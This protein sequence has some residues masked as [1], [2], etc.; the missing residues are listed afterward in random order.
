[1]NNRDSKKSSL[2]NNSYLLIA[3]A[4]AITISFIID[5][6]WSGTSTP[7]I[8]Q[9]TIQKAIRK[10]Q[11]DFESFSRDT[12]LISKLVSNQYNTAALQKLEQKDYFIFIYKTINTVSDSCIFWSTQVVQPDLAIVE[13]F[14]NDY[15]ARLPNG[16]YV[17]NKKNIALHNNRYKIISLIPVKWNYYVVNKYLINSFAAVDKIE[18]DYEITFSPGS[19]VIKSL[20]GTTLFYLHQTGANKIVHNNTIALWLKIIAALLVLIF[21]NIAANL[22]V[23]QYGFWEGL[24]VLSVP[25]I[26]LRILSYFIAIPL[27]FR[28]LELFDPVIY[29]SSMILRSLGD[30]LINSLLF[31]WFILF[32]RYHLKKITLYERPPIGLKKTGIVAVLA[33]LMILVTFLCGRIIKSLVADS[34]ISFDVINFFTINIYSVVGFIVLCCMATGY[35]FLFQILSYIL[36]PL[37]EDRPYLMYFTLAILG[38]LI[39]SVS[40][41]SS[42]VTFNLLLLLWLL[43][44][45]FLMDKNYHRLLAARLISS[46]YVFWI[47]FFSVS[48]S[49]IIIFENSKKEFGLRK[50]FAEN[51][52]NKADTTSEK[53]LNFVVTDF[54]ND[55]LSKI[56]PQFTN[57]AQNRYIKDSLINANFSAY[58]SRYDTRVYTFDSEERPLYNVDSTTFNTLNTITETQGRSTGTA[59]LYYYDVS[60]DVFNYIIKK[61]VIDT[62]GVIKGYVYILSNPKRYKNN[63]ALYPELF[64]KGSVNSIENSSVYAFAI[65]NK[66]RLIISHNDYPFS[67]RIT[68][69]PHLNNE[70]WSYKK[71]GY[72]ELWYKANEDKII[73]ITK[74]N[75][76]FIESIT[77]FAYLFCAFL[78]LS[79]LLLLLNILVQNKFNFSKIKLFSDLS[80]RTQI[81][82]TII[83]IS[84]FSFVIIGI[85]TILFFISRYHSNNREKLSRVIQVM[86]NEVRDSLINFTSI[87]ADKNQLE[88]MIHKVS[89]LYSADVNLYDLGG[90]L[91]VSSLPLPYNTGIVSKK[92]DP[93]AFYHLKNLR[94]VQFFQEQSIGTLSYL[95]NYVPVRNQNGSEIAYLNIPYFESENKL[96]EEISN[97]LVTIINL[98]AFIFLVAGIIALFITNRVTQSFSLISNKMKQVNL[99]KMNEMIVWN[100]KDEIGELVEEYNK[101]VMKLDSS[102]EKLARSER[103]GAWREMARQVAHEIKNPLTPMRLNLQYLQK[104]IESN[105]PNVKDISIYVAKIL[106]E[107]IDHLSQIAGDFAQF[108]NIGQSK[109]Q[110]FNLA[111]SLKQVTS[112]YSSNEKLQITMTPHSDKIMIKADKTQ[113]NRL[114]TNLL[115]NAVESVPEEKNAE[116]NIATK[117]D[118][119][120][121]LVM[122][123]DNGKGIPMDMRGKIFTPNFTTKSSGTGLGLAMCKGIVEKSNGDIW[124]ETID[125]ESTTFFVQLPLVG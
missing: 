40:F 34:Q 113:I 70:F 52:S 16:W 3:A 13:S 31:V 71:N 1:L 46:R 8:V 121:V 24:L 109:N 21:I 120:K 27:N 69:G 15:L 106:V 84:I 19:L 29:G 85:T 100:K 94:D 28:Q 76:F 43:L 104:A 93:T 39:L 78:A 88:R 115:Q 62:S 83:L 53:M 65:Y 63:D 82:G 118:E 96:E 32:I 47:F 44:F 38:L 73:V 114:F 48:I 41:N 18:N 99:G 30:L 119:E 11:N 55:F 26:L 25:V 86:Q 57:E 10:N 77:L 111:D 102:A 23:V 101:M 97:F 50:R 117:G 17:A 12:T 51:L 42:Y 75:S 105:S 107:Q 122:I 6:Y 49:G 59:G 74:P 92:M 4:W 22:V 110:L 91:Q 45:V 54:G 103:E 124:F 33:L 108:A 95:S 9:K 35:F 5:N 87:R 66:N 67:T 20:G 123:T 2:A 58:L 79:A 61:Q 68:P 64:S 36:N 37:I 80:I 112:L 60:Y 81:H 56:F 125:G 14:N 98:N 7:Q 89:E 90:N 72:D 116:I